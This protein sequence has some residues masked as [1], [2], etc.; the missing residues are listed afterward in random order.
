MPKNSIAWQ[1]R[2]GVSDVCVRADALA[3]R[4][5]QKIVYG[6]VEIL[7]DHIP[8]RHFYGAENAHPRKI[9]MVAVA[10]GVSL[11]EDRFDVVGIFSNS[12]VLAEILDHPRHSEWTER[13]SKGVDLTIAN[14]VLPIGPQ[15]QEDPGTS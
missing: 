9:G 12:Q 3:N 13:D 7:A 8:T 14:Q 5:A 1:W 11:L 4:A 15:S 2:I 10:V 6:P